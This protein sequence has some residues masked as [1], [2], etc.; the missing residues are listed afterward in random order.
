MSRYR[1]YFS[2]NNTLIEDN[3]TNNSQNPVAEIAYGTL[4][5]RVTRFI[6]DINLQPLIDKLNTGELNP[7]LIDRHILNLSNTIRVIPELVGSRYADQET[8]RAASFQLELFNVTEDWDEGN[9]YDFVYID[10][11]FPNLPRQA[12]N[13]FDRKTNIEWSI[14]GGYA[15]GSTVLAT[16]DFE[17]GSEDFIVDITDYINSRIISGTTG[18]TATTFGLGIKFPDYL[19]SG[20]TLQRQ[21]VAFHVK[22]SPTFYEPYVE[23]VINDVIQ[24]DREYFYM[25][26]NN[27]LYLYSNTGGNAV[28]VTINNVTINDYEGN[29]INVYTGDSIERVR[30]GVYK[31]SYSVTD[32]IYPDQVNFTDVWNVTINGRTKNITQQFYLINEDQYYNFD[33]TNRINFDNYFFRVIGLI[34]NEKIEAGENRRLFVDVN[35]LYPNQNDILPLDLEYRIYV[36][37]DVDHIIEVIPFTKLDRTTAGYETTLISEWLIPQDYFMQV[38]MSSNGLYSTRKPLR[39]TVT[40]VEIN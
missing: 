3:R 25:N 10:E 13:W 29:V 18:F 34:E 11:Q 32:E 30:K 28:D 40:S 14:E 16:L 39:F 19:E 24:D 38:R 20:S 33:K 4:E 21:A 9:G 2:K 12:S 36:K 35:Q 31:I 17:D 22:D 7:D 23:T 1:S 15:T 26:K 8:Q 6:F 27:D 5:S 37:Q